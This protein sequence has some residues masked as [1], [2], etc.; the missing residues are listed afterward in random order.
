MLI[1]RTGVVIREILI[2]RCEVCHGLY[3]ARRRGR[4]NKYCCPAC[5]DYAQSL[6]RYRRA[7][8]ALVK[9]APGLSSL[10]ASDAFRLTH[11]VRERGRD[12]LSFRAAK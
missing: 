6:E 10:V 2:R 8:C 4:P 7:S 5:R 3:P 12:V 9:C 11:E 1:P